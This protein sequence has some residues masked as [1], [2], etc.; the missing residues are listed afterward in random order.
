LL[1]SF[2]VCFYKFSGIRLF[3]TP[4]KRGRL[5]GADSGVGIL[6]KMQSI[7]KRQGTSLKYKGK[8]LKFKVLKTIVIGLIRND[9]V[10]QSDISKKD[11]H[12]VLKK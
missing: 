8:S 5:F 2:F 1:S 7:D 3:S 9:K 4:Q 12:I 10:L 6:L 11:F